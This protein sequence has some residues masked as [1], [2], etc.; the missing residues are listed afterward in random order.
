MRARWCVSALIFTLTLFGVVSQQ[1]IAVPNQEIVLQFTDVEL[2]SHEVQHTIEVVKNQLLAAG[3]SHIKVKAQENGKLK[4]S[5]YSD[6]DVSSIKRAFTNEDYLALSFANNETP[7][8]ESPIDDSI[9]KYNLDIYEIQS[10]NDT[11]WDFDGNI[12][13]QVETKS[14]RFL[15]PNTSISSGDLEY[16]NASSVYKTTYKVREHVTFTIGEDLHA[17]PE[18]RAGPLS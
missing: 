9:L 8:G 16:I 5:Y 7:S 14:D 10:A 17:I 2:T 11:G 6:A 12:V 13:L 4:I 18:V 15:D 3:G 1:Q